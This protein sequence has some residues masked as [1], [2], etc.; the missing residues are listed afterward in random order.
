MRG[1]SIPG[2]ALILL[3]ASACGQERLEKVEEYVSQDPW[4]ELAYPGA[5]QRVE[6]EDLLRKAHFLANPSAD[7]APHVEAYSTPDPL[8]EVA[9]FYAR[10]YGYG[11]L[12]EDPTAPAH[13]GS[14]DFADMRQSIEQIAA[15]LVETPDLEALKGPYRT[16]YFR[17]TGMLP[18]ISLQ[19]PYFDLT[20]GELIDQTVIVMV[21]E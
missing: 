7:S 15:K 1:R 9:A 13:L 17:G 14:G 18:R 8:N 3:L 19:R 6:Q 5:E 12:P 16:A 20:R 21:D 10:K 2:F 4:A 11:V